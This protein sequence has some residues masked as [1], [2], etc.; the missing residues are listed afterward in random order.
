[1]TR[2]APAGKRLQ[3]QRGASLLEALI[4]F[5]VL[6]GS[7]VAVA[8]VQRQMRVDGDLARQ[9]AEAVRLGEEEMENLRAF[10]ALTAAS[11]VRSYA[12]I[13]TADTTRMASNASYRIIRNVD[14]AGGIGAKAVSVQV[15]WNDRSGM[16]RE[17][18]LASLI[19]RSDPAYAGALGLG[20][21]A[22]TAAPRGAGGRAPAVPIDARDLGDGR[23]AWKPNAGATV[24][25]VFDNAGGAIVA[26]CVVAATVATRDI[27][28]T[29]LSACVSGRSLLVGGTIRFTSTLPPLPASANDTPAEVAVALS[30]TGGTYPTPPACFAEARSTGADRFVAW[31]CVVQPRDDGRWSGRVNLVAIAGWT[32]GSGAGDRRVCR[33]AHDADASGAIDGNSEHPSDY[34]DVAAALSAQNFLVVR[35]D[36]ACPAAPAVRLTGEGAVVQADLG[37]VS[38]QPGAGL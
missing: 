35:G 17:V 13:V 27:I 24:S 8:H 20:A 5:V 3:R 32:I 1:M 9:R 19:A 30:L 33:F 18:L 25:F 38:H 28:V 11:G 37:T 21:G 14:D 36:A 4:A 10:S 29:D 16:A 15:Q 23:S 6:A 7:A 2:F 12:A 26:R 22:V 31:H 34:V